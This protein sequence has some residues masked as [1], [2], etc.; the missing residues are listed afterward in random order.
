MLDGALDRGA[1]ISDLLQM[2]GDSFGSEGEGEGLG[3]PL[4]TVEVFALVLELV[5]RK[6]PQAGVA[7]EGHTH[8][9][10]AEW[11]TRAFVS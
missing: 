5:W 10:V 4:S 11:M 9:L 7:T 6:P 8:G 1:D 2:A 3:A